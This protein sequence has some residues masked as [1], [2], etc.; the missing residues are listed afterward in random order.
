M[1]RTTHSHEPTQ[2]ELHRTGLDSWS[3]LA[4]HMQQLAGA[5]TQKTTLIDL[6]TE[7][8]ADAQPESPVQSAAWTG[9]RW[10]V[11]AL[12]NDPRLTWLVRNVGAEAWSYLER[13]GHDIDD[14]ELRIERAW[15]VISRRGESMEA[16]AHHDA[17][18]TA[19]YYVTAPQNSGALRFLNSSRGHFAD[20]EPVEGRLIIF[21]SRQRHEVLENLSDDVRLS[22]SFELVITRCSEGCN[23]GR[24][25]TDRAPEARVLPRP[26]RRDAVGGMV[27]LESFHRPRSARATI[28][29]DAQAATPALPGLPPTPETWE[30]FRSAVDDLCEDLDLFGVDRT[31]GSVSV[32]SISWRR[33]VNEGLFTIAPTD[34]QV[35]VRLDDGDEPCGIEYEGD[36]EFVELLPGRVVV[37]DG[38]RRHRLIGEG[39][40]MRFGADLPAAG[41]IADACR[42]MV[43]LPDLGQ[44][45]ITGT[46]SG[47]NGHRRDL[48]PVG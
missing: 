16:H 15:P 3:P 1:I 21:P 11:T 6:I 34:V 41:P 35:F 32:P 13:M 45:L 22:I 48:L 25:G 24:P 4:L 40:V 7:F 23:C 19:V 36:R 10:G 12:H 17:H 39:L 9:D 29:D 43:D 42:T 5:E 46:R 38:A 37:I 27:D 26:A 30:R 18:L 8:D 20:Y 33:E 14:L 47:G 2:D 31:D 44:L 28:T